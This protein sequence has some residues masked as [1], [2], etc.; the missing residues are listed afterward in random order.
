VWLPGRRELLGIGMSEQ[1]ISVRRA[2]SLGVEHPPIESIRPFVLQ[3]GPLGAERIALYQRQP[4]R[5][6]MHIGR[7][8]ILASGMGLSDWGSLKEALRRVFEPLGK[9]EERPWWQARAS[10]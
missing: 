4:W 3:R 1:Q 10:A 5:V 2:L 7:G 9:W 8:G 6:P